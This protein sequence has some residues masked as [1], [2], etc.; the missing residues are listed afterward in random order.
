MNLQ[1]A[2]SAFEAGDFN[3]AFS[4]L[5]K[6]G[7]PKF[8]DYIEKGSFP[9]NEEKYKFSGKEGVDLFLWDVFLVKDEAFEQV[10]CSRYAEAYLYQ[11]FSCYRGCARV[12][13]Q[14]L[15]IKQ[16]SLLVKTVRTNQAFLQPGRVE[17]LRAL[18]LPEAYRIHQSVWD[19][20]VE[21]EM[22]LWN[23][24]E[25]S[26][27]LVLKADFYET[28]CN[29]IIW[30]ESENYKSG[31]D[32]YHNQLACVYSFFMELLLSRNVKIRQFND[33]YDLLLLFIKEAKV[34][35]EHTS[36]PQS[37]AVTTLLDWLSH[38]YSYKTDI[39]DLYSYDLHFS[40]V[41]E[42]G[43]VILKTNAMDHY[44]WQ[45][46]GARY[47]LNQLFYLMQADQFVESAM[48]D[49][50]IDIPKG[51]Q[52]DDYEI[53]QQLAEMKYASLLL[54]KD[55]GIE[56]MRFDKRKVSPAEIITS[57]FG[58]IFN[59]QVRYQQPI[60]A[61]KATVPN[62]PEAFLTVFMDAMKKD[63]CNEPY[64]FM[65]IEEF[66]EMHL[67]ALKGLPETTV[68]DMLTVFSYTPNKERVFD[69]FKPAYEVGLKL[70]LI[71]GDFL[72]CPAAFFASN[73]L[74]YSMAQNLMTYE[75]KRNRA[76]TERMEIYF[77]DI[78]KDKGWQVKLPDNKE[79][80][81]MAGDADII[82]T[83]GSTS[84]LIQLKNPYFRVNPKDAYAEQI[85]NDAKA[86]QQL[87]NAEAWLKNENDIHQL[88]GSVIKWI[89][90]SS[91]EHIGK[92]Y[93]GCWKVNYFEILHIFKNPEIKTIRDLEDYILQDRLLLEIITAMHLSGLIK[94][95]SDLPIKLFNSNAYNIPL[96]SD[97]ETGQYEQLF[98]KA[99]QLDASEKKERAI[100]LFRKC[101]EI[102][103]MDG[104]V[105]AALANT[106]ADISEYEEA[107]QTFEK[108]LGCLPDDPF[109]LRNYTIALFEA[110]K[111][112]ESLLKLKKTIEKYPLVYELRL[113]FKSRLVEC[114]DN[115]LLE[116][117]EISELAVC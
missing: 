70:F 49:G 116:D 31:D 22:A 51:N 79:V 26:L 65:T 108:A 94:A 113:I 48:E 114:M 58:H 7:L 112:Y 45:V 44:R 111:Y 101:I 77:G 9:I 16:P 47:G 97:D 93:E 69:R 82:V 20:L 43:T 109:I 54:L 104:E 14:K 96:F 86:A 28:L 62:W 105:W 12:L 5:I 84:L 89:V 40:P 27:Q 36:S 33:S 4:E 56:E 19:N 90:S 74:F 99:I 35:K 106:L 38:W 61:L 50:T 103:E 1:N 67:S 83:D 42:A 75:K 6:A 68:D 8:L 15:S 85:I 115:G 2:A 80:K 21:T 95:E 76:E 66:K 72:F 17:L 46:N 29:C 60:N 37:L 71:I 10:F 78:L 39:I 107:F 24:V 102:N 91:F 92:V 34:R 41:A 98:N 55:M 59:K 13:E 23:E 25:A 87:N 64:I 100:A 52:P 63:I 53:N 57:L 110:G 81:A 3:A 73:G 32:A 18:I 30:V 117:Y 88:K 11:Y